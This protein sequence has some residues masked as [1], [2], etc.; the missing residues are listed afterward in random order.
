MAE[1]R[2]NSL[3]PAQL[4]VAQAAQRQAQVELDKRIVYAGI[5]G[6]VEQFILRV[7]AVRA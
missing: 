2:V 5:S 1:T 4:A 6:K 7:T 3:L